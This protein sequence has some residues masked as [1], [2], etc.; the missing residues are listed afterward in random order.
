[1]LSTWSWPGVG[2]CT[3]SGVGFVV[4]LR[5]TYFPPSNSFSPTPSSRNGWVATSRNCSGNNSQPATTI[6]SLPVSPSDSASIRSELPLVGIIIPGTMT[7]F[8]SFSACPRQGTRK[9]SS[10]APLIRRT[11]R[12]QNP[13]SHAWAW[14][15]HIMGRAVAGEGRIS[16]PAWPIFLDFERC[17]KLSQLCRLPSR[18][19]ALAFSRNSRWG[20]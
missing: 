2:E 6:T 11:G 7:P 15:T 8:G 4:T 9:I 19:S 1:M 18:P 12:V 5:T 17:R 13:S 14:F 20:I 16:L 3:V 10:S